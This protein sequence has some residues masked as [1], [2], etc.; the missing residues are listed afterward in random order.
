VPSVTI[1]DMTSVNPYAPPNPQPEDDPP[2]VAQLAVEGEG[3]TVEFEQTFEDLVTF[4]DYHSRQA[5]KGVRSLLVLIVVLATAV[6]LLVLKQGQNP[7]NLASV[8]PMIAGCVVILTLLLLL[9]LGRRGLV[10]RNLR[11]HYGKGRNLNLI[12][13]RRLTITP[14]YVMFASPLCQ[15]VTRWLGMEKVEADAQGIYLY[16]TSLTAYIIPRRAFNSEQHQAEFH[17][18]AAEYLANHLR[19]ERPLSKAKQ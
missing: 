8:L 15:S 2:L 11:T 16:N 18:K 4:A 6:M 3:M 10:R 14:D 17:A 13:V 19:G 5:G 7:R 1:D 12:G 9:T